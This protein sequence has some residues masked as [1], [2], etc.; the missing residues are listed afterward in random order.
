MHMLN[1]LLAFERVLD[2]MLIQSKSRV[3]EQRS[4]SPPDR[5]IRIEFDGDDDTSYATIVN[6][7]GESISG[8]A[9]VL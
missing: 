9:H 7:F 4:A 8:M 5:I 1:S 6:R 3:V 2:V